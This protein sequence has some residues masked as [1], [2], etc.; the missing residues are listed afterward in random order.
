MESFPENWE[1]WHLPD[2]N[3]NASTQT[4]ELA[5][6]DE[7]LMEWSKENIENFDYCEDMIQG[8]L[9]LDDWLR[10]EYPTS[11]HHNLKKE[12][13]YRYIKYSAK[14]GIEVF[15]G[16]IQDI[17][18]HEN[19]AGMNIW[20]FQDIMKL[21]HF[22]F[23]NFQHWDKSYKIHGCLHLDHVRI[24]DQWMLVPIDFEHGAN[25]PH[26]LKY[27][28]EAYQMQNILQYFPWKWFKF[29][30]DENGE[31]IYVPSDSVFE[32]NDTQIQVSDMLLGQL[33]SNIQNEWWWVHEY[34]H[35]IIALV[36]KMLGGLYEMYHNNSDGRFDTAI[37]AHKT[38]LLNL[39][40]QIKKEG[41]EDNT[42]S[43]VKF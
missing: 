32:S 26:R 35:I 7:S 24:S 10:Q 40:K 3:F 20:E 25:F 4:L 17:L 30:H 42:S 13:L 19:T 8:L 36:E 38:Y 34:Q 39:Y 43:H 28:D 33:Y 15:R 21:A 37:F 5:Y 1:F 11:T 6:Y 29:Q 16:K 27:Q 2:R 31:E 23:R 12:T 22:S 18:G 14:I 41:E 9:Y